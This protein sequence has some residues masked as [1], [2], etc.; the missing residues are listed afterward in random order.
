MTTFK[1]TNATCKRGSSVTW[2]YS[3]G[4]QVW[5]GCT[6]SGRESLLTATTRLGD[7]W[8]RSAICLMPLAVKTGLK[9][10]GC[11]DPLVGNER[12]AQQLF[13]QKIQ[14]EFG[15]QKWQEDRMKNDG[16]FMC[17]FL[18]SHQR[19]AICF[20]E[21]W[22]VLKP[23][24]GRPWKT[25]LTSDFA[26]SLKPQLQSFS[27][28]PRFKNVRPAPVAVAPGR[29]RRYHRCKVRG[30]WKKHQF[31]ETFRGIGDIP[32]SSPN[33]WVVIKNASFLQKTCWRCS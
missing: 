28:M 11:S 2:V 7:F 30:I 31:L 20:Q 22:M 1:R 10:E 23:D 4:K 8:P 26:V 32:A 25:R 14:V 6:L 16:E 9:D 13:V 19:S 12:P 21:F 33:E 17:Q 15:L 18:M 5:W 29:E 24:T 27:E 3:N